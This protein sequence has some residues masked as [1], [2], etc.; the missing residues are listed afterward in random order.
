MA[1]VQLLTAIIA[2]RYNVRERDRII[3]P[4]E[5]LMGD[6]LRGGTIFRSIRPSCAR[7]VGQAYSSIHAR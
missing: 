5:A 1:G 3:P 2:P 7:P 4:I 6:F